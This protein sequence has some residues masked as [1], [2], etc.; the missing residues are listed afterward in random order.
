MKPSATSCWRRR[1][2][3]PVDVVAR[4]PATRG[5]AAA[6]RPETRAAI[7]SPARPGPPGPSP[8]PPRGS[9]ARRRPRTG[10]RDGRV[11]VR[12]LEV[13]RVLHLGHPVLGER[14]PHLALLV[15]RELLGV[16]ALHG[17][18]VVE[19][20]DEHLGAVPGDPVGED[21]ARQL[22]VLRVLR[23]AERDVDAAD[24]LRLGRA[25]RDRR[26]QEG[27][28]A[29]HALRERR[30]VGARG[31]G[32][33]DPPG[34]EGDHRGVARLELVDAVRVGVQR[35][36]ALL[37][38]PVGEEL[39]PVR[40]RLDDPGVG[41]RRLARLR[42]LDEA[43][44]DVVGDL[45]ED[46][47]AQPRV[48]GGQQERRGRAAAERVD[49]ALELGPRGRG[50]DAR[51][52]EEVG[53][54]PEVHGL[55]EERQRVVAVVPLGVAHP[56]L[57]EAD[58]EE[59]RLPVV[60]PRVGR[61]LLER[62][63]VLPVLLGQRAGLQADDVGHGAR[64][65]AGLQVHDVLGVV[66][67]RRVDRD[68]GVRGGERVDHLARGLLDRAPGAERHRRPALA[69]LARLLGV[70]AAGARRERRDDRERDA[71]L[72]A[73]PR[74]SGK[75]HRVRPLSVVGCEGLI[76][77]LPAGTVN[78]S[79]R[80]AAARGAPCRPC[81]VRPPRPGPADAD[82]ASRRRA[83]SGMSVVRHGSR[84]RPRGAAAGGRAAEPWPRA[85]NGPR[86]GCPG[87]GRAAEPLR[88]AR[89]GPRSQFRDARIRLTC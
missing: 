31:V 16:E 36:G 29:L 79:S 71:G 74:S 9:T 5:V 89:P 54:G 7:V 68:V 86:V 88:A 35:E 72:D 65:R 13:A 81:P 83:D 28:V 60:T 50:L 76:E 19:R 3:R 87:R 1:V 14:R 30:D 48:L 20:V 52:V 63:E 37:G 57:L 69:P 21:L 42:L 47:V 44:L 53:V 67:D 58:R 70:G 49:G 10:V 80:G 75:L 23:D 82:S 2:P 84:A 46:D 85:D 17:G 26:E 56:R 8:R 25:A 22:G 39:L 34:P 40:E 61:A 18:Q 45:E 77:R 62:H 12:R 33:L 6:G 66:E 64:A 11:D 27:L 78:G 73:A 43:R 51:L 15:A 55:H 32:L 38:D 59:L 41:P 24:E 4:G